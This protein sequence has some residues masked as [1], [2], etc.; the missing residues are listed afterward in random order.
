M[1]VKP[2]PNVLPL[3]YGEA[4]YNDGKYGVGHKP[5]FTFAEMNCDVID[6][7]NKYFPDYKEQEIG[8]DE[9]EHQE[10]WI[11]GKK[12]QDVLVLIGSDSLLDCEEIILSGEFLNNTHNKHYK[13]DD[14]LDLNIYEHTVNF[15]NESYYRCRVKKEIEHWNWGDNVKYKLMSVLSY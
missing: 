14:F 11:R 6:K 8:D 5:S 15:N 9:F 3:H 10:A 2:N 4:Y 12:W 7:I 1:L 13:D